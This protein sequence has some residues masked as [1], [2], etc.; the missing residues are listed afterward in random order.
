MIDLS[1]KLLLP[2]SLVMRL[3]RE[4]ITSGRLC[5]CTGV[6]SGRC[7]RRHARATGATIREPGEVVRSEI[8]SYNV[9]VKTLAGPAAPAQLAPAPTRCTGGSLT[10]HHKYFLNLAPQILYES[11]FQTTSLVSDRHSDSVDIRLAH[12]HNTHYQLMP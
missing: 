4:P 3:Q 1:L 10:E 5:R 2:V 7:Y 12:P 8:Y 6:G 9:G 11:D